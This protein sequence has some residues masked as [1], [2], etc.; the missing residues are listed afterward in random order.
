M[1]LGEVYF[2]TN[3]IKDWKKL[4]KPDK[5]KQVI[6]EQL[7]WLVEQKKIAVYGFVIMPNH[8]H[9]IWEM[10]QMNGKEMPYASLN[11]WTSSSFLRDLR[12]HHPLALS[13]F[14]EDT[15]ERKHRFWQRDPLAVLLPSKQLVEQKLEYVHLNPLQEHWQLALRPEDY[16]WSSAN[17]YATGKDSFSILT[18]YQDRF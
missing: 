7:Q 9:L 12:Q 13:S 16:L 5:Y 11:K 3:T 18:H 15:K 2:W 14:V 10:L 8:L 4:L 17:F 6:L 1:Q